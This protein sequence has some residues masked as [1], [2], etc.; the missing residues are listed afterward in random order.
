LTL[1]LSIEVSKA[2]LE[3]SQA[4]LDGDE[5]SRDSAQKRIDCFTCQLNE[6]NPILTEISDA[7]TLEGQCKEQWELALEHGDTSL[8][9]EWKS[10]MDE[11]AELK[12]QGNRKL[13]E[14]SARYEKQMRMIREDSA[15][16]T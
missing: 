3:A 4:L 13:M 10:K 8:A 11:A 9:E 1:F 2:M 16:K 14:C 12:A 6:S 15:T 7:M 5:N